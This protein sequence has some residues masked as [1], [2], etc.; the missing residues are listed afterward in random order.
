[1]KKTILLALIVSFTLTAAAIAAD[2][3]VLGVAEFQNTATGVWWYNR[4]VAWDLTD[5]LTNELAA[6]GKFDVVERAKVEHVLDEQDLASYGRV[7]PATAAKTGKLIG[8]QYL[9]MGAVSAFEGKTAGTGGGIGYKGIRIGGKKEKERDGGRDLTEDGNR[10][11]LRRQHGGLQ[12]RLLGQSRPVREHPGRQG[13]PGLHHPHRRLHV[14]RHGRPGRLPAGLRRR[15]E[16]PPRQDQGR[17]QDRL[18][19]PAAYGQ[20]SSKRAVKWRSTGA[21]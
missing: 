3:P 2:K 8:A 21:S 18:A 5:M 14:V 15:G 1:M 7:D 12:G 16:A 9:V 10:Q 13:H 4:G 17:D 19:R 11:G 20:I 6:T